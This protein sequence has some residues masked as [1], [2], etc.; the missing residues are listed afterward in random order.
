M[1]TSKFSIEFL[2]TL[3]KSIAFII[4]LHPFLPSIHYPTKFYT[5]LSTIFEE[6]KTL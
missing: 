4:S 3:G 5:N 6:T 2:V 1:G